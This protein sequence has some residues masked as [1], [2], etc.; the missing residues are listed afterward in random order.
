MKHRNPCIPLLIS[1]L[2]L[3]FGPD[4]G[5]AQSLPDLLEGKALSGVRM[6]GTTTPAADER[7]ES[8]PTC[9][10]CVFEEVSGPGGGYMQHYFEMG[11]GEYCNG[12]G[13]APEPREPVAG[14]RAP[15][16]PESLF[17]DI[18]SAPRLE[19][20]GSYCAG[21]GGTSSCHED[22]MNGPCHIE[23]GELHLPLSDEAMVVAAQGDL[24]G[25]HRLVAE[26]GGNVFVNLDRPAI[27][28][29]DC[30]GRVV[31]S[32]PISTEHR[33]GLEDEQLER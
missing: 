31:G 25:T 33:A 4:L 5:S 23:C 9:E 24:P 30:V 26:A 32:F 13:H 15:K 27:Q 29:L 28:V 1:A 18:L 17:F 21:C 20:E 8:G 2:L 22:P 19:E 16:S 3:A 6:D 10:Y 11:M 7:E 14:P 12:G